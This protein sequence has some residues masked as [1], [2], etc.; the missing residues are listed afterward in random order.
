M[1][2]T[3]KGHNKSSGNKAIQKMIKR[4]NNSYG[5]EATQID[6]SITSIM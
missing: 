5:K 6:A 4:R 1:K 3:Y 2:S